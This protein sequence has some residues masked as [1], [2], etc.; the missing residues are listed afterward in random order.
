M[1]VYNSI[2]VYVCLI[3]FVSFCICICWPC[4][5]KGSPTPTLSPKLVKGSIHPQPRH[6]SA[7]DIPPVAGAVFTWSLPRFKLQSLG[8]GQLLLLVRGMN[9][10][11]SILTTNI[12]MKTQMCVF[13]ISAHLDGARIYGNVTKQAGSKSL[14]VT[15]STSTIHWRSLLRLR[16]FIHRF[17]KISQQDNR[18][19]EIHGLEPKPL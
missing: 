12:A 6:C 11:E 13:W 7:A 16:R 19:T 2:G 5:N 1:H 15:R 3:V 14:H 8:N 10:H 4:R 9:P 17:V 18:I